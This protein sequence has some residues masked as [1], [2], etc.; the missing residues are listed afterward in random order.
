MLEIDRSFGIGALLSLVM[1]CG[2]ASPPEAQSPD[3]SLEESEPASGGVVKASSDKVQKGMD[4]IQAEDFAA[5][6]AVLSEARSEAP[7]DPQAAFYLGVALQGL[8]E[9]EGAVE[10][11]RAALEL[12]PKLAEAAVNLSGTL[13]DG[14]DA[15]G[16]LS[17][18]DKALSHT[19]K[20]PGL[21][22]NR[23]LCLEAA[24]Q[25]DDALAAYA[26]AVDAAPNNLELR[27]AYVDLLIGA[28]QND[29][30]LAALKQ[31]EAPSDPVL[32]SAMARDYG[33]L[34]RPAECVAA[35]DPVVKSSPSAELHV[36]RGVCRHDAGDDPGAQADYEAALKLDPSS[37]P[38]HYY[39]GMHLRQKD[40]AQAKKHLQKAA[41]LSP[42][43]GVGRAAAEAL[44]D[45]KKK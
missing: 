45:L 5:A 33:R 6:K 18:V 10:Q 2:G 16:A 31:A 25:G 8:G 43:Q 20:H 39:L 34:K 38:A 42:G 4:A 15:A 17:V 19:P 30:A 29:Q 14:G 11:Y 22:L 23:A 44:K 21:L 9:T 12:D 13:L 1:A 3:P 28:G 36:R 40:R 27:L 7:K 26:D 32:A 37:A 24:G 41:E 35:L